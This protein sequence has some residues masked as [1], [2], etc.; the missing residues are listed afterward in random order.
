M[1]KLMSIIGIILLVCGIMLY[2]IAGQ[3]QEAV[4]P[5]SVSFGY[6]S[7][8]EYVVTSSGGTIGGNAE[9]YEQLESLKNVGILVGVAGAGLFMCSLFMKKE[10]KPAY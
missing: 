8:G 4:K 2:L 3:M 5:A 10:E 6:V 7:N 9:G 1:K